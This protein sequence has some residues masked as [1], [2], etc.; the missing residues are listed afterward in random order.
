MN[1]DKRKMGRLLTGS[2]VPV[3]FLVISIIAI[4]LSQFSGIYLADQ[5]VTRLV[6]N[7]FLVLSLLL[8]IMAGM[9]INFGMTL[10]A[11]AGQIWS[12]V[13]I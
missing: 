12:Y 7:S 3:L 6:R 10:G 8:P 5:I 1:Y 4:P 2:A 9:G 13:K 11:M